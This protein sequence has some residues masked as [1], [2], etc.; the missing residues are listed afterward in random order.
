MGNFL[1]QRHTM[2]YLRE[3][4][5][6]NSSLWDKRTRDKAES[7]GVRPIQDAAR[8]TARRLLKEH[9]PTPLDRDVEAELARIVASG[10]QRLIKTA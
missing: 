7:E 2:K 1:A 5:M 10:S 6:R 8:E 3:G 9:A 4:E